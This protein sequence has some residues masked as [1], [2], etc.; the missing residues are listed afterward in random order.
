M[1]AAIALAS[2]RRS[3]SGTRNTTLSPSSTPPPIS[4]GNSPTCIRLP[5]WIMSSCNSVCS[6]R[7]SWPSICAPPFALSARNRAT[8]RIFLLT[9]SLPVL[10]LASYSVA[11]LPRPW[12]LDRRCLSGSH[13]PCDRGDDRAR[14][15]ASVPHLARAPSRRRGLDR[16]RPRLSHRNFRASSAYNF[17]PESWAGAASPTQYGRNSPRITM[18]RSWSTVARWRRSCCIIY[19][20]TRRRF[21]FGRQGPTPHDHYEMTRPFTAASPEPAFYCSLKRCPGS[22][23]RDCSAIYT[24][25]GFEARAAS[26]RGSREFLHFCRLA[27]YKGSLPAA[28]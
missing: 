15:L 9:F 14:A 13:N 25:L 26:C 23:G 28:R 18:A 2:S 22:L 21:T 16:G 1:A 19:A 5:C 8:T 24:H 10:A 6:D 3:S 17:S 11:A 7:S 20:T 27:D 4:A 12:Q